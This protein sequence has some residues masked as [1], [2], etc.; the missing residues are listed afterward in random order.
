MELIVQ[1]EERFNG[2]LNKINELREENQRLREE[3]EAERQTRRDI[4][5][6]IDTL[7]EKIKSEL[8]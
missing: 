2:L 3:V 4:E 7:L 6:R 1:L 5:S 8:E